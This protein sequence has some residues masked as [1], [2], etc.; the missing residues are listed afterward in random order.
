MAKYSMLKNLSVVE[1]VHTQC[2]SALPEGRS[3][4]ACPLRGMCRLWLGTADSP[5]CP[6]G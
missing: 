1:P 3:R 5:L 4:E 6:D 2:A